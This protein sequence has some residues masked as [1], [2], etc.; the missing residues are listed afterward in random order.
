VGSWT[1]IISRWLD[2]VHDLNIVLSQ[3]L[4]PD[5]V[6]LCEHG[7]KLVEK[8]VCNSSLLAC[9]RWNLVR[10]I[11]G[12]LACLSSNLVLLLLEL[13]KLLLG[14]LDLSALLSKSKS[15]SSLV[16]SLQGNLGLLSIGDFS[17]RDL[18]LV[19]L[20]LNLGHVSSFSI[21]DEVKSHEVG[22]LS[23][24]VDEEVAS[25]LQLDD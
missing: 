10:S 7:L 24:L 23:N 19:E 6:V 25:S 22:S 5:K 8:G 4:S 1:Q 17:T 9:I 13:V 11:W 12:S 15:S 21:W 18:L 14:E 16:L 3:V 2:L 20:T